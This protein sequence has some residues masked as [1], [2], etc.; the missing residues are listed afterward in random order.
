MAKALILWTPGLR[1]GMPVTLSLTPGA[2]VASSIP[3][4]RIDAAALVSISQRCTDESGVPSITAIPSTTSKACGLRKR[5]STTSPVTW[6]DRVGSKLP[7]TEWWASAALA[8]QSASTPADEVA[9]TRTAMCGSPGTDGNLSTASVVRALPQR[10]TTAP[11]RSAVP[12]ARTGALCPGRFIGRLITT[13]IASTLDAS[14]PAGVEFE[15]LVKPSGL[16]GRQERE[17]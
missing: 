2:N 10:Q 7:V 12:L 16:T 5:H 11:R 14:D 4:A 17:R 3:I 15:R 13:V 8:V 9:R 1:C 6:M